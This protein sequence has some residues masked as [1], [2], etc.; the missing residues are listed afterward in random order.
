[1]LDIFGE[2]AHQELRELKVSGLKTEPAIVEYLGLS[3]DP[4]LSLLKL[5]QMSD[6]A[7][8]LLRASRVSYSKF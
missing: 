8:R 2:S 4:Y 5:E 1:M 3:G 7:I 6:Q